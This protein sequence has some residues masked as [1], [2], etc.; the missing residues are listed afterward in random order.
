MLFCLV[1]K[2]HC[3]LE[4]DRD[5]KLLS[6]HTTQCV[7]VS[8]N[9]VYTL[10]NIKACKQEYPHVGCRSESYLQ[11]YTSAFEYNKSLNVLNI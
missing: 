10:L 6:I 1:G 11:F 5:V 2:E 3:R 8:G 7:R 9:R 4:S